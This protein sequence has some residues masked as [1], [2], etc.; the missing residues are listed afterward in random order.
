MNPDQKVTDANG[1]VISIGSL[2]RVPKIPDSLTCDLPSEDVRRLKGVEGSLLR[3]TEI[4][5][6]GYVWLGADDE[7]AGW[8]CLRPNEIEVPK[9]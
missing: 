9:A 6:F 3:V 8:F 7:S 1:N 2:V 4:D 5:R